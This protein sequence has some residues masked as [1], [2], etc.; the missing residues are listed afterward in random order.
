MVQMGIALAMMLVIAAG[1][2]FVDRSAVARVEAKNLRHAMTVQRE[3]RETVERES[4]EAATKHKRN[5]A[6]ADKAI[7]RLRADAAKRVKAK[8]PA[9]PKVDPYCRP[10]CR[11]RK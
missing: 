2:G 3:S 11:L 8:P 7:A 1:V 10:G 4:A 5:R 9:P 6:K